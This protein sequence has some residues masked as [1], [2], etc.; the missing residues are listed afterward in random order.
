MQS[1]AEQCRRI[2]SDPGTSKRLQE[3]T[4]KNRAIQDIAEL[5]RFAP[6]ISRKIQRVELRQGGVL[7][8]NKTACALTR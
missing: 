5:H 8:A 1:N 6:E 4:A 2:Q 7:S 3:R